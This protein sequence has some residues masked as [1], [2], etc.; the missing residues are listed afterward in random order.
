MNNAVITGYD[1]RMCACCSGL[2]IN[3]NND[4][5][6]FH[7]P[8]YDLDN[9]PASMGIDSNTTF[10]LYLKCDWKADTAYCGGTSHILIT[11]FQR[12]N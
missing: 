1:L 6:S 9:T 11:R 4:S 12:I 10:P 7:G 3:F 2:L 5:L 8:Y